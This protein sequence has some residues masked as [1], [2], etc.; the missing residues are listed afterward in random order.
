M[1]KI[2]IN[3][4]KINLNLRNDN[5]LNI[6]NVN[7]FKFIV[8]AWAAWSAWARGV[9]QATMAWRIFV[10]AEMIAIGQF[11]RWQSQWITITWACWWFDHWAD[12][13]YG[14]L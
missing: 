10:V 13:V 11:S 9:I 8:V 14:I 6:N 1:Y 7:D 5:N 2:K 3:S 4:L 12:F